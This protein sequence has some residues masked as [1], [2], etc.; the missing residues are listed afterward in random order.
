MN[1]HWFFIDLHRR[2]QRV[3]GRSTAQRMENCPWKTKIFH[4]KMV[5]LWFEV[6]VR[7]VLVRRRRPRATVWVAVLFTAVFHWTCSHPI[8][9]FAEDSGPTEMNSGISRGLVL[10]LM[11]FVS[12]M[13]KFVSEMRELLLK[14]MN[15]AAVPLRVCL[16][17][18]IKLWSATWVKVMI[19]AL[20]TGSCVSKTKFFAL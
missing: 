5:I 11:K 17:I 2:V 9:K 6:Q 16:G 19:V 7:H 10:N 15:F 12:E 8:W 18:D 3:W 13:R 20:K 4:W 1:F 14:T